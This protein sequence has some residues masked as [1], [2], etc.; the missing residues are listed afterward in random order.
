[1]S[2]RAKRGTILGGTNHT[3]P[4]SAAPASPA[5]SRSPVAHDAYIHDIS[6]FAAPQS[7]GKVVQIL[8]GLIPELNEHVARFQ[9]CFRRGR[10]RLHVR[11][12]DAICIL[13]KV[14]DRTEIGPIAAATATAGGLSS[15]TTWNA[16]RFRSAF[17]NWTATLPTRSSNRAAEGALILSHVSDGL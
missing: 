10:V 11:K 6:D 3:G 4:T 16:R 1:M 7:I 5:Q 17:A 15:A 12:L 9:S 13:S 8:D 2:F 14:R